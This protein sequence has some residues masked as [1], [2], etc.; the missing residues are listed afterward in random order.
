MP[1][2]NDTPPLVYCSFSKFSTPGFR[3]GN[4]H[5][6]DWHQHNSPMHIVWDLTQ[7]GYYCHE[8][9]YTGVGQIT[10]H[11]PVKVIFGSQ[12]SEHFYTLT[13]C[14]CANASDY[15]FSVTCSP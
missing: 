11:C 3:G 5:N 13:T 12:Y 2:F 15:L 4:F 6:W 7:D 1:E 8:S 9:N 14:T 10:W